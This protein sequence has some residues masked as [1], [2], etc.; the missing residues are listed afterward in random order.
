M[1]KIIIKNITGCTIEDKS[2]IGE[3]HALHPIGDYTLCGDALEEYH[4][5]DTDQPVSCK[6]CL[7]IIDY[8]RGKK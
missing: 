8:C 5:Y 6:N 3:I 4:Y 7:R 2:E 1:K